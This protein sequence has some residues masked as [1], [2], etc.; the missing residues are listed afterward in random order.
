MENKTTYPQ[1]ND[2][3]DYNN[4]VYK[5]IS[6]LG[7]VIIVTDGTHERELLIS[8]TTIS[9]QQYVTDIIV[10]D[11]DCNIIDDSEDYDGIEDTMCDY[12]TSV[13]IATQLVTDFAPNKAIAFIYPCEFN[14]TRQTWVVPETKI[15]A[16]SLT[17]MDKA[18]LNKLNLSADLVIRL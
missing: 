8:E 7:G 4:K 12:N 13:E 15:S 1:P 16:F 3:V 10:F 9:Q 17:T 2:L 14:L 6:R 11:N 18:M 5:V